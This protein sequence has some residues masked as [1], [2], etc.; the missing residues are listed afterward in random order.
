MVILVT[1]E[2]WQV[3]MICVTNKYDKVS[4]LLL[5]QNDNKIKYGKKK[6][7]KN[8]LS[9]HKVEPTFEFDVILIYLIL[10]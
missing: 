8:A 10:T 7:K 6:R 5:V 9:Y 4:L 1:I 3:N 2:M